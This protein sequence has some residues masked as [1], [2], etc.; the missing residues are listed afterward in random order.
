MITLI[1]EE[2]EAIG[3]NRADEAG[4]GPVEISNENSMTLNGHL[5]SV[6]VLPYCC[7]ILSFVEL[8]YLSIVCLCLRIMPRN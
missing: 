1:L 5:H 2:F 4:V 7:N 6:D 8:L 3:V